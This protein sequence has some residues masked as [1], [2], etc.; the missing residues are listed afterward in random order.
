MAKQKINLIISVLWLY[1]SRTVLVFLML[2]FSAFAS[3]QE[4][5]PEIEKES[6]DEWLQAVSNEAKSLGLKDSVVD[7][8][9]EG[10]EPVPRVIELDRQQPEFT[11]SFWAYLDGRVSENR[12]SEGK[13]LLSEHAKLLREIEL[14]H[15]VQPRFLIA[16]W[17]LETNFGKFLGGF[18]V[19][20]SLATLAYDDRRS[21]FFRAELFDALR[22]LN[23]GHIERENMMGSWAGAMGQPQ[24]MPSTFTRHA[25]DENGDGRI[26]IWGSLPDVFGSAANYLSNVGWNNEYTWGREVSLPADFDLNLVD[27]SKK[28]SLAAWQEAGVRRI[29]GRDLPQADITGALVLPA[30]HKGPAFLVY[31]NFDAIMNWNRSLLYA[32]SVGH[33]ADRLIGMGPLKSARHTERPLSRDQVLELQAILNRLGHESG[34]PDGQVGPRTRSAIQAFQK[35][36]GLPADGYPDGFVFETILSKSDVP[37]L[38]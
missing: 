11:Q 13:R 34:E 8:A 7:E 15:G 27:L 24:F 35:E 33:L 10:V 38:N 14:K 19:I 29:D 16:F 17:G 6:F 32:I 3:A 18:S 20:E 37:P 30:G 2:G 1:F 5:A 9:L 26:D 31:G 36:N 21:A 12:I 23:G 4:I 25:I 22:I 28:R